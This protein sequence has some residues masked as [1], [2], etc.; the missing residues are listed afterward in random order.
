MDARSA[1]VVRARNG[2]HRVL[3]R[4]SQR[5]AGT[6]AANAVAPL[7]PPGTTVLLDSGAWS[8]FEDE[9]V[10]IDARG[11]RLYA[12]A[13]ATAPIRGE[14]V[15]GEVDLATGQRRQVSLGAAELDDHNSAAIWESPFGEVLT[16]WSR[17]HLDRRD[18]HAPAPHRRQLAPPA[19]CHRLVASHLQQPLL[20]PGRG[21]QRDALRLL[22]RG[23]HR[24]AGD[25]VDGRRPHVEQARHGAARPGRLGGDAAVRAIRE[26]G[27]P[28]RPHRHRGAPR[29]LRAQASIT[30]SSAP[31][32]PHVQRRAARSRGFRGRCHVAHADRL[33]GSRTGEL[34]C[35]HHLRRRQRASRSPPTPRRSARATTA[36]T[37]R[38][39]DGSAWSTREIAYAGRSL[40]STE[41]HYTGLVALDPADPDH[42]VISTDADPTTGVPLISGSDGLRHFELFDGQ[43]QPG[44]SYRWTPLT[45]HSTVNNIRPVDRGQPHGH[46]GVGLATGHLR[47]LHRL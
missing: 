34:D 33:A 17:H 42:V 4:D 15:L 6:S 46:L 5:G 36:I 31:A 27:R 22:P 43:R 23:P 24:S 1:G 32:P 8:W 7:V 10:V 45:A 3:G 13:V 39:W 47:P 30:A 25:G 29:E 20:G 9:R 26:Q 11:E 38:R 35:R 2:H 37:S 28:H 16:A 21:R 41:D 19:T 14:V 18:H 44:G 12:S 40:Y